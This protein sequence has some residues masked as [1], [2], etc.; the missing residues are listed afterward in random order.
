MP[1]VLHGLGLSDSTERG[2][3]Q[4]NQV[5]NKDNESPADFSKRLL[6]FVDVNAVEK[7]ILDLRLNRGGNGTLLRP[8]EIALIKSP[9]NQPGRLFVMMERSTL[10]EY[11]STSPYN[12][13]RLERIP[14]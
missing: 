1:E 12:S 13:P 11:A 10:L 4:I 2:Y 7:L 8:L 6:A 9:I 5:G 14:F 3:A